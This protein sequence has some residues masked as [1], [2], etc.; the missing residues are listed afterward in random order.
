MI[1]KLIQPQ[2]RKLYIQLLSCMSINVNGA[3]F[4]PILMLFLPKFYVFIHFNFFIFYK[5]KVNL[6]AFEVLYGCG[7]GGCCFCDQF[8][9]GMIH[10][11]A[12]E[13]HTNAIYMNEMVFVAWCQTTVVVVKYYRRLEKSLI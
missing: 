13:I 4:K 8:R 2:I 5:G 6:C 11:C 12:G 7:N 9:I 10:Y 1:S 3:N